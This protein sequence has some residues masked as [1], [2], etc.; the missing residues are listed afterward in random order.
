MD[1]PMGGPRT[2]K[3]KQ[4]RVTRQGAAALAG[5]TAV[6]LLA[7]GCNAGGGSATASGAST[8]LAGV[9]ITVALPA[10]S[11]AAAEGLSTYWYETTGAFGGTVL[12]ASGKPQFTDPSSPGYKAAQ[13]MVDAIKG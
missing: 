12:D 5:L 2:M 11:P 4:A 6:A 7:A 8:D 9:T 10:D 13:W 3:R 1:Q